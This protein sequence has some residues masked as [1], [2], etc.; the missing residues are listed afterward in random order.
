MGGR[1]LVAGF[2]MTGWAMHEH[3]VGDGAQ[4]GQEEEARQWYVLWGV[5]PLN[6]VNTQDMAEGAEDYT[7]VTE[8]SVL[9]AIIGAVL[10]FVTVQSRTVTVT[11]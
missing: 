8:T 11:K 2:G 6:D 3:V 1:L 10:S 5:V 4:M 7:I 9:D